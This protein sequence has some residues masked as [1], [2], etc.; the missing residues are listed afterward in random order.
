MGSRSERAACRDAMN[1]G[2]G[3][4]NRGV[5]V[6]EAVT[7]AIGKRRMTV[8]LIGTLSPA[9]LVGPASWWPDLVKSGSADGRHVAL[10]QAD[11]EKWDGL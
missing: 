5:G 10:L 7:G 4:R 9:A 6:C 1:R 11:E 8:V 3:L 2:V